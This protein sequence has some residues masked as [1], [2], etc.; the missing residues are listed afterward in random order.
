MEWVDHA[1]VPLDDAALDDG[2]A[3][4]APRAAG[5]DRVDDYRAAAPDDGHHHD[6]LVD[7]DGDAAAAANDDDDDRRP[8]GGGPFGPG[9]GNCRLGFGGGSHLGGSVVEDGLSQVSVKFVL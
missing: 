4:P 9:P 6:A 1:A 2:G 7:N 8:H 5:D 3:H